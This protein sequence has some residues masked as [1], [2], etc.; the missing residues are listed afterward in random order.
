MLD[1]HIWMV[2]VGRGRSGES[3]SVIRRN[4]IAENTA[5]IKTSLKYG[6]TKSKGNK[7][8][9]IVK[10]VFTLF[11][12]RYAIFSS[13]TENKT[14]F[15]CLYLI[16]SLT[17]MQISAPMSCQFCLMS[18]SCSLIADLSVDSEGNLSSPT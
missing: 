17:C 8:V 9:W 3:G 2:E 5:Q 15:L 16:A 1:G 4:V 6:F 18:I 12:R 14:L 10:S 7:S 13:Q 11:Q